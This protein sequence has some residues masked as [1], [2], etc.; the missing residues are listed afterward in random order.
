MKRFLKIALL[1]NVL[2]LQLLQSYNW[3]ILAR[4]ECDEVQHKEKI[5][6]FHFFFAK[7]RIITTIWWRIVQNA[8]ISGYPVFSFGEIHGLKPCLPTMDQRDREVFQTS[9]LNLG[10]FLNNWHKHTLNLIEKLGFSL[11]F[12]VFLSK[13]SSLST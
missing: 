6:H 4:K 2:K 13:F 9:K 8:Y 11:M 7:F 10:K 12:P 3:L 5:L 1:N